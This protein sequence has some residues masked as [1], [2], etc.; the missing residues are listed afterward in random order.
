MMYVWKYENLCMF[1][2]I[3]VCMNVTS[4]CVNNL[5]ESQVFILYYYYVFVVLPLCQR[6]SP[7]LRCLGVCLYV[8]SFMYLCLRVFRNNVYWN[9]DECMKIWKSMSVWCWFLSVCL[10]VSSCLL[11]LCSWELLWRLGYAHFPSISLYV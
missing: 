1:V 4:M 5:N 7:K 8:G 11:T 3:Y 6:D 2:C 10:W 9:N